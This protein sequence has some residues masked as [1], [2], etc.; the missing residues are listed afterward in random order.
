MPFF[1]ASMPIVVPM[2]IVCCEK[3]GGTDMQCG[4]QRFYQEKNRLKDDMIARAL[5]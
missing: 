3:S 1:A 5:E 2:C 4:I